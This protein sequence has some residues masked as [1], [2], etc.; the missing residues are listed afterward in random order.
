VKLLQ[1]MKKRVGEPGR[2]AEGGG[3]EE[4]QMLVSVPDK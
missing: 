2:R 1:K 3:G 4:R